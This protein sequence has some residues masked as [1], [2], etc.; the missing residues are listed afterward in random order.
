MQNRAL[1]CHVRK[2]KSKLYSICFQS[3][4][5]LLPNYTQ[6]EE[7]KSKQPRSDAMVSFLLCRSVLTPRERVVRLAVLSPSALSSVYSPLVPAIFPCLAYVFLH[8]VTTRAHANMAALLV[9]PPTHKCHTLEASPLPPR[10]NAAPH[11]RA[12]LL[13][14]VTVTSSPSSCAYLH[15]MLQII[16]RGVNFFGLFLCIYITCHIHHLWATR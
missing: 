11:A 16:N 6:D 7:S 12:C 1:T 9:S 2:Q 3:K 13:S 5:K 15:H 8:G 10:T 14:W 4:L